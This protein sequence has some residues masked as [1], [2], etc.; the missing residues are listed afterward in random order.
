MMLICY[1]RHLDDVHRPSERSMAQLRV[2]MEIIGQLEAQVTILYSH[3]TVLL[4]YLVASPSETRA[5]DTS[6][7]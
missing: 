6:C 4:A 5:I 2:Q 3:A 7:N 1:C